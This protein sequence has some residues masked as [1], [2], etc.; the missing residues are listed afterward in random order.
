MKIKKLGHC[1]LL[2]EVNGDRILTDPGTYS[3][4]QNTEKNIDAIL[5]THEH[6][7]HFHLESLKI[8]LANNP[9]A[10]IITN[11]A[12]GAL[13]D[14][15]KIPYTILEE[16]NP[17]MKIKNTTLEGFGTLHEEIY[18][19]WNRVQNTGYFIDDKLFY[20][21]DTFTD[22]GK[23]IEILALPVAGPWMKIKEAIDYA[24]YMKPRVVFPV[25]DGIL[26]HAG[27]VHRVPTKI[28]TERG[29]EF[30]AMLEG[31]EREF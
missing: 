12:V 11:S 5:I 25:H 1:C 24:S 18:D 20:P 21:G 7:D 29:I 26:K 28:L 9:Q 30:V 14:P 16:G 4:L 23:H 8:V 10:V 15:E 6:Q 3:T 2:I 17:A 22:P 31:D 27:L 19:T 13:L